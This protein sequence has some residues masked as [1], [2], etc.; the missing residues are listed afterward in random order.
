MLLKQIVEEEKQEK[1]VKKEEPIVVEDKKEKPKEKRNKKKTEEEKGIVFKV[2][3]ATSSVKKELIPENFN[4]VENVGLY[5]AGGLFRYTV[6]EEKSIA[7]AN[8]LQ[9]RLKG[10]GFKDAFI[11]AFSDGKRISLSEAIKLQTQ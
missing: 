5:E 8:L 3:I 11:V 7:N 6:G 10:K 2:Q 1:E 9:L 4:G